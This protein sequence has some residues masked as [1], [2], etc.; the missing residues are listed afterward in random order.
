MKYFLISIILL[1]SIS[2][3]TNSSKESGLNFLLMVDQDT[4]NL[5]YQKVPDNYTIIGKEDADSIYSKSSIKA[6]YNGSI[7]IALKGT[8]QPQNQYIVF[9][10]QENLTFKNF[11]NP[12]IKFLKDEF[13]IENYRVELLENY[14]DSLTSP[15]TMHHLLCAIDNANSDTLIFQETI[16]SLESEKMIITLLTYESKFRRK[17]MH[18]FFVDL[19]EKFDQ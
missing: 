6:L 12:E 17:E 7:I 9:K 14:I 5:F 4:L 19:V 18:D 15:V 10:S 13:E 1:S 8:S 2:C 16:Y 11:T 3:K